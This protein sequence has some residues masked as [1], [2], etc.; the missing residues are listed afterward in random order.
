MHRTNA[1][2]VGWNPQSEGIIFVEQ[3]PAPLVLITAA[4]TDIQTLAAALP[5]LPK[6]F[7]TF[8]V[9]N[10]LQLQHQIVIDTYAEQILELAQVIVIRLIGGRSYWSYGFE[11]IQEIAER[12]GTTLIVMPGD[13]AL[14][15]NLMSHSTLPLTK[16]NQVWR[17]FN[18]GG[19][20]NFVNA[21]KYI[22]DC[23]ISTTFNP[24]QPQIVPRVGKYLFSASSTKRQGAGGSISFLKI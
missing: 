6:T 2:S 14:D 7:P 15:Q 3:T 13:D 5:K 21:L 4:D 11:V 17:Y 9:T 24:P 20:D 23:C 10:L 18:E 16:V 22:S 8:R 1:T 19:T 12:N